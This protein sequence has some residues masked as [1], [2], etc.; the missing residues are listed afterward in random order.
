MIRLS[1]DGLTLRLSPGGEKGVV[2]IF[3]SSIALIIVDGGKT[4]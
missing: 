2:L 3:T 1:V 4:I